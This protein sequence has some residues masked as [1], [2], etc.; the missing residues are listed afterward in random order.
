MKKILLK[1]I[2]RVKKIVTVDENVL[3]GGFGSSILE[4]TND[5][6]PEQSKKI[7]LYEAFKLILE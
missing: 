4:F 5:N 7:S 1:W 3:S 2:P 6:F